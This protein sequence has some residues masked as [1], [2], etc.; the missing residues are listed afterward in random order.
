MKGTLTMSSSLHVYDCK[1]PDQRFSLEATGRG[2]LGR[3]VPHT[4]LANAHGLENSV[5]RTHL[6]ARFPTCRV[7]ALKRLALPCGVVP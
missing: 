1:D 6:R 4:P 2:W 7:A 5:W 3:Q